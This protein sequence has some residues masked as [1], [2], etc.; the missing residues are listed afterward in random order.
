MARGAWKRQ[1]SRGTSAA[2]SYL[3]VYRSRDNFTVRRI[4]LTGFPSPDEIHFP[5]PGEH[6]FLSRKLSFSEFS[7]VL[8]FIYIYI[9]S[10]LMT[11]RCD[12]HPRKVIIICLSMT[13]YIDASLDL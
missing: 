13:N 3:K 2:N 4:H 5:P 6:R 11:G 10:R 7:N 8:R 12:Y 1:V 9:M